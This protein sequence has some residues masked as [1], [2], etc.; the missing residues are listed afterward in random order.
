MATV[1]LS[2]IQLLCLN[3]TLHLDLESSDRL[4]TQDGN[5]LLL[6]ELSGITTPLA[7]QNVTLSGTQL[8]T[9]F[10]N[11]SITDIVGLSGIQLSLVSGTETPLINL[12]L[13]GIQ[14]TTSFGTE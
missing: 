14:L 10:G 1:S 4:I 12:L 3:E 7:V 11:E 5:E 6:D 8:T 9:G 13:S 2:G